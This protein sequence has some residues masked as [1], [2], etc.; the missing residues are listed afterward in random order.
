MANFFSFFFLFPL[1]ALKFK[2][3]NAILTKYYKKR[4]R[5]NSIR[6]LNLQILGYIKIYYL[7]LYFI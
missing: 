5:K 1:L 3:Q 4:K 6:N 7:H 2:I